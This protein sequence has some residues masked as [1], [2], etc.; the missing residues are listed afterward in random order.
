[1]GF[2]L[3]RIRFDA[4]KDFLGV[5]MQQ[6]RVQLDADWNEW[7][8]ELA[9]RLQAG[10]LDV[11]GG[12]AVPRVTPNGFLIQI[13]TGGGLTIGPGRIYVDGLLAENHGKAPETWDPRLAELHGTAAVD[14]SDQPYYPEPPDLPD[15]GPHLVYVDVWQRDITPVE[16]PSLIEQAVGVDTTG[17]RQTVW[18]VKVL[19]N[20][21]DI[22]CTT[23]DDSIPGWPEII[24][25]S[26][27]RLSTRTGSPAAAFSSATMSSMIRMAWNRS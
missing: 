6:G 11:L 3:S 20:V 27:A 5:V 13:A 4:R 9:R 26:A 8:A 15:G 19:P 10:T 14:Y 18:Q 2:D 1:M 25:P 17:R 16:E 21:G 22:T 7:I 12:N 24:A 23:P